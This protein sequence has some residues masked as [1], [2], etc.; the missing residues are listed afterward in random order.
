MPGKVSKKAP[1]APAAKRPA[2]KAKNAVSSAAASSVSVNTSDLAERIRRR[3]YELY[4]Q[5]GRQDGHA[6]QDWLQAEHEVTTRSA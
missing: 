1:S 2:A 5:R 6:E 3:A 4:C